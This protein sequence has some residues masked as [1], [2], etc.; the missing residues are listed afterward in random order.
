[1]HE[2]HVWRL[3][4]EKSCATAHIVLTDVSAQHFKGIAKIITECLH[5]YGIHSATIQPEVAST[6]ALERLIDR[7]QLGRR[8]ESGC[9]LNC[10]T[11]CEEK[12][13]CG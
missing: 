5:A 3:N 4:E 6:A 11:I 10:G 9:D 12:S 13:C 1:V 7:P 8:Q 2:L